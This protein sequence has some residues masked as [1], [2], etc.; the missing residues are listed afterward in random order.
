METN[1]FLSIARNKISNDPYSRLSKP[2][3]TALENPDCVI[4][5]HAHIFDKKCLTVGYILLRLLKS[6]IMESLGLETF[7]QDDLLTKGETEIYAE[8]KAD[9]LDS[10]SDW[11]Q[12]EKELEN[13]F[14]LTETA[15]LFGFNLKEAFRVLKK[16]N[17]LDVLDYYLNTFSL[18]QIPEFANRPFVSGILMMDL[19][20]GWGIQPEKKLFDQLNEIKEISLLRPIIPFF[21]VD[22]RRANQSGKHENLYEL[23]L[24][25]FTDSKAPL[26]GVKCYPSLGYFP[27]D[28]RLDPI[29]QICAEK[30]IPVLTHC[31]G[32]IVSTFEKSIRV[33][34]SD[35]EFDFLIPGNSR[36]E[37][38]RYLNDPEHWVSVLKKYNNLKLNF[39][40]FGGDTNWENHDETGKNERILRILEMMKNTDWKVYTDFSFNVVEERLFKALKKEL[41]NS[42]E[43]AKKTMFG[44]DYW[45]V[46]PAGELLDMQKKFLIQLKNH[47][48]TLL[49][50]APMKYLLS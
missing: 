7:S 47:Q 14:E 30:N 5:I 26:F 44:T 25:A 22:P 3:K 36:I 17:M 45:V 20:T 37:R 12:L 9:N 31:G 33:C 23:F 39:G 15:E 35:G 28:S 41:D 48:T 2:A 40:H 13:V 34:N 21:P 46:L 50:S 18:L 24:N 10:K 16:Q 42:T 32:E 27:W 1:E 49:Q 4:D 6:K 43:I 29:F 8:I 38:A 11:Q 19:E